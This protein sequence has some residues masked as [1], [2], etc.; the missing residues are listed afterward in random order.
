MT[1]HKSGAILNRSILPRMYGLGKDVGFSRKESHDLPTL[2]PVKGGAAR[3]AILAMEKGAKAIDIVPVGL[4]F[5]DK[6]RF[7]SSVWVRFGEPISLA[8]WL[9]EQEGRIPKAARELT[10]E[11]GLRL[12]DLVI[13]LEDAAWAPYI[14]G[15]EVLVPPSKRRLRCDPVARLRQRNRLAKA[16]NYFMERSPERSRLLGELIKAQRD[17]LS[18]KG[19]AFVRRS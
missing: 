14:E 6:E 1:G 5:E 18:S 12:R 9:R 17:R 13:H 11:I 4:N 15:L 16:I 3:I 2:E 10:K 19:L 8:E 7:R